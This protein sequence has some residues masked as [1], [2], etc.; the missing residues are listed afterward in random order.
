MIRES[1][2]KVAEPS[3]VESEMV[4]TAEEVGVNMITELGNQVI[5]GVIPTEWKLMKVKCYDGKR[6]DLETGNCRRLKSTDQTLK[7]LKELSRR[8]Y[9]NRQ[10]LMQ[11]GFMSGFS[12]A[13]TISILRQLQGKYFAKKKNCTLHL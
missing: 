11:F 9:E 6:D 2:R 10:I 12:T 7:L 4:K 5:V 1:I 13:N 3:G 8:W